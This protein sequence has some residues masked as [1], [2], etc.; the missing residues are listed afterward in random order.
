MKHQVAVHRKKSGWFSLNDL[1]EKEHKL[2][3][4][5][6]RWN[7]IETGAGGD[8]FFHCVA[9]ALNRSQITIKPK[10]SRGISSK[11]ITKFSDEYPRITQ[12]VYF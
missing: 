7:I 8:C 11:F 5:D 2:Q 1:M 9:T 12:E 6:G 10:S 4:R 3:D